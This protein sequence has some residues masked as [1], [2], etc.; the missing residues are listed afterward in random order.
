[1]TFL[2]SYF[3][4]SYEYVSVITYSLVLQILKS[5]CSIAHQQS[6]LTFS[7]KYMMILVFYILVSNILISYRFFTW[8]W[9]KTNSKYKFKLVLVVGLEEIFEN[10]PVDQQEQGTQLS[11]CS[12]RVLTCSI[13]RYVFFWVLFYICTFFFKKKVSLHA[14]MKVR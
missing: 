10:L 4:H 6:C 12:G 9:P 8:K 14:I 5:R 1:M 11:A 3:L 13:K 2:D 7:V